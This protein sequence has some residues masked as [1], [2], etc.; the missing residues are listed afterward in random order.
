MRPLGIGLLLAMATLAGCQRGMTRIDRQVQ[1]LI[2]ETSARMNAAATPTE[3]RR[4]ESEA[5]F[6]PVSDPLSETLA[7]HNPAAESMRFSAAAD[8]EEVMGRLQGF[9]QDPEGSIRMD[10]PAALAYAFQHSR[11]Y[12]FEEEEYVLQALRL[13]IERHQWGP[14]FFD[15]VTATASSSGDEGTFDSALRVVNDFRITQRLPWG[16]SVSISALA[17][18]TEDLHEFVAGENTQS[19]DLVIS[20]DLP[21]LRG[22]GVVARESRIQAERDMVYAARDFERFRRQ[23]TVQLTQEFLS[24]VVSL[25]R[26]GNSEDQVE[27][28]ESIVARETARLEAGQITPH[29]LGEAEQSLVVA[30]DNLNS[31]IENFRLAVDRFKLTIGMPIDQPLEIVPSGPGLPTPQTSLEEAVAA[32]MSNRL[33]LQT[34][35]DR[36]DDT[37]RSVMIAENDLLPDLNLS[38]SVSLPTDDDKARAGLDFKPGD[39]EAS[40][41]ITFGLPIDREIERLA[42]R[43]AQISLDRA[44]RNYTQFRDSIAV[45]V[46]GVV[47]D[48]DRAVVAVEIQKR[49]VEIAEV[50]L[51]SI[52]AQ[53]ERVDIFRQSQAVDDLSQARNDYDSA[54]RDL[55][56][57]VMEYLFAT[58]QLR[59]ADDGSIVPLA[60]ME[61]LGSENPDAP[62]EPAVDG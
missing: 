45:D 35:R 59:V 47:R 14:R 58:G 52:E 23:F 25:A 54:V 11:D 21:L 28:L 37:Q 48:I 17:R 40:I 12:R 15:D 10:L 3:V 42:L 55:Q 39:G 49:G 56:L 31:T 46:R 26:I 1:Q 9:E 50:R 51:A 38:G 57:A 2:D 36:L 18:A 19:A 61:L 16:G 27:N 43:Q 5:I 60:G 7:T 6:D 13:L 20:A 62:G 32:A 24:L 44:I 29:E 33:D 41:G 8:T 34:Q 4:A 30:Q 53:P 22:A